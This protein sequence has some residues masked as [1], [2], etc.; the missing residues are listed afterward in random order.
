[1]QQ[2]GNATGRRRNAPATVAWARPAG[3]VWWRPLEG[4]PSGLWRTPGKRVG[5][6][7][8]VGS[9]PTPSANLTY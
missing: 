1:M 7:P 6:L 3:Y 4:W 5:A 2:G 8:L 9:N